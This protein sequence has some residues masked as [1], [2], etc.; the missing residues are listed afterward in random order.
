[1]R[2]LEELLSRL[3][4]DGPG[5]VSEILAAFDDMVLAARAARPESLQYWDESRPPD[6]HV[7]EDQ[8]V[9]VAYTERLV[10]EVGEGAPLQRVR[11]R[12]D[13]LQALGVTNLH[14]L[15][16]FP[17]SGD[18]GFAI[19][20][21]R[22]VRADLGTPE[23]LRQ[24]A[25]DLHGRRMA[26][27]LDF[28]LNHTSDSHPWAVKARQGDP[29]YLD[30]FVVD[31]T[32]EGAHWPGV[33]DI[34]P[35]FAPGHWDWVPELGQYLWATFYA[36]QP[37]KD[38]PVRND[39]AQ[40]DL[41]YRNPDVLLDMVATLLHLVNQGVDCV[42]LDAIP[43]LW[44][45]RGTSCTSQPPLHDVLRVIRLVVGEVAPRTVLLAEA[46]D[47]LP[48]LTQ[49]FG[50]GPRWGG[51]C[52]LA[53][54]FPLMPLLW[55]AVAFADAEPLMTMMT[56]MPQLPPGCTWLT[57]DEVH[58]EVSLEAVEAGFPGPQGVEVTRRLF[59]HFTSE[60]RGLPFRFDPETEAFGHGISSNRWTMLGGEAAE[61][62]GDP[63]G[64]EEALDK[65]VLLEALKAS[66][67][68][69]PLIYSGQEVGLETDWGY[70]DDPVQAPDSR[71]AK[72]RNFP[73][74]A[75]QRSLEEGTREARIRA[76]TT[77]ILAA[78]RQQ[79]ALAGSDA[80]VLATGR[81]EVL[82][83]RRRGRGGDPV[84]AAFNFSGAEVTVEV[85]EGTREDLFDGGTLGP[86]DAV[87]LGPRSFRWLREVRG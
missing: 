28:V 20:D 60:R 26:L 43:F 31:E 30:Y 32:G 61:A 2:E 66:V 33:P 76:H 85:G 22:D 53:Y 16:L 39:F 15:P 21:Y 42:R 17:T 72:R 86:E 44:K 82:A 71:F 87:V 73:A 74:R 27:S 23:D 41:D 13:E 56:R 6:W 62:A 4:Q 35:D 5:E 40:W 69:T 29:R 19:D 59:D 51:T 58:D 75:L 80:E 83:F 8:V 25:A 54:N 46:N 67:G 11:G 63:A 64:V 3:Y 79:P 14:L 81:R 50:T 55:Y 24:L 48:G 78:R 65:L 70:A 9:Y 45:Q 38:G 57:F 1:M 68:G 7:R 77:R 84:V 34:F 52:Q 47:A 10:A 18:G 12:L 37:D 49:Y 36:R